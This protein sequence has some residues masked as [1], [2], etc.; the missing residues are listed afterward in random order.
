MCKRL[1]KSEVL[2]DEIRI[3]GFVKIVLNDNNNKHIH[4]HIIS[5]RDVSRMKNL[6]RTEIKRLVPYKCSLTMN[7][8]LNYCS[9]TKHQKYKTTTTTTNDEESQHQLKEYIKRDHMHTS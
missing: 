7:N 4:E 5:Q 1:R 9:F 2:I 3:R 8:L 6:V